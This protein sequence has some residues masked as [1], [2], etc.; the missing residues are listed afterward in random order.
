MF[1]IKDNFIK[2]FFDTAFQMHKD[3]VS[4]GASNFTYAMYPDFNCIQYL[5]VNE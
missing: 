3:L 1:T 4:T 2:A 5:N